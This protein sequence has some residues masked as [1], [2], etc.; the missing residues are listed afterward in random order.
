MTTTFGMCGCLPAYEKTD[1]AAQFCPAI[2]YLLEASP[3]E[4]TLC[5]QQTVKA[6]CAN[7][8]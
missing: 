1:Q 6:A 7:L 2:S 3:L 4:A 5:S 8:C